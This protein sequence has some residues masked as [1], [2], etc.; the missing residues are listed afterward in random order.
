MRQEVLYLILVAIF[1]LASSFFYVKVG[2]TYY[3]AQKWKLI[4]WAILAFLP[5]LGK[6]IYSYILEQPFEL[7]MPYIMA[8]VILCLVISYIIAD[9][10]FRAAKFNFDA[11]KEDPLQYKR[12][13]WAYYMQIVANIVAI[14]LIFAVAYNP[15]TRAL[16]LVSVVVLSGLLLREKSK[17][18]FCF[19]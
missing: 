13:L 19:K 11:F 10:G 16:A 3:K 15:L 9:A 14:V 7:G 4:G 8:S 5:I 6:L 17:Y 1:S 12:V 2:S 18:W